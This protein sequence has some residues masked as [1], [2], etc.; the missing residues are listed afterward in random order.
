MTLE[1]VIN[2]CPSDQ[3]IYKLQIEEEQGFSIEELALISIDIHLDAWIKGHSKTSKKPESFIE[4]ISK[5]KKIKN[6]LERYKGTRLLDE[7]E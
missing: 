6:K 3:E 1:Q 4:R 5:D 7:Y 2:L